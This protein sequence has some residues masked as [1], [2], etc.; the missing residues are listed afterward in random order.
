[1]A[2]VR[3]IVTTDGIETGAIVLFVEDGLLS[4]LEYFWFCD[5]QPIEWPTANRV[6]VELI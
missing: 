1:M 3:L 5:E 4:R 2:P 6:L